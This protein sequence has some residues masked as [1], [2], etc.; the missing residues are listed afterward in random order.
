MINT[1]RPFR[2]FDLTQMGVL[3][4]N[5]VEQITNTVDKYGKLVHLDGHS[6]TSREPEDTEGCDYIVVTGDNVYNSLR[7][8]H[9]LYESKLVQLATETAGRSV[10]ISSDLV[11]GIN[12]NC[13]RGVGA[14]Y[15]W[16][17]DSNPITGLL[18]VTTHH[19]DDG[20]QLMLNVDGEI[21]SILPISGTFLAF[22]FTEIPHGVAPLKKNITR[23][24]I[25]MNF[26]FADTEQSRPSDLDAYIFGLE[27]KQ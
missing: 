21:K 13:I 27:E 24:S 14:R 25:P 8:F 7:W 20:G 23:I 2:Q 5:W 12:I 1:R 10:K 3:P 15:E 6:S 16:H 11:S 9:D 19:E 22:D 17:V 26:Y 18:F 4:A